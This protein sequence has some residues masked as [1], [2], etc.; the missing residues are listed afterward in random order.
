LNN[1]V[2]LYVVGWVIPFRSRRRKSLLRHKK[3]FSFKHLC[4]ECEYNA[5]WQSGSMYD[6]S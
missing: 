6:C 1:R 3:L 4:D 5:E 2:A